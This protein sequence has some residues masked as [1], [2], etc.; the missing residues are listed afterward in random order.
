MPAPFHSR[1]HPEADSGRGS[2][3]RDKQHAEELAHA[4]HPGAGLGQQR[5]LRHPHRYKRHAHPER[6]REK[7]SAAEHNVA[8]LR[9]V[10]QCAGERRRDAWAHD[11][12]REYAHRCHRGDL[13]AAQP[14]VRRVQM[15]MHETR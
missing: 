3:A 8:S 7:R 1:H 6:H 10:E 9:D 14:L 13:A 15:V 2:I 11:H 12:R 5:P 4:V